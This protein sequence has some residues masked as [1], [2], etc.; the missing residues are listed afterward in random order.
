MQLNFEINTVA[1]INK[2]VFR[3]VGQGSVILFSQVINGNATQ[4]IVQGAE[5]LFI[6][7]R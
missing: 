1:A 4:S 7:G 6:P 5:T 2:T 3:R